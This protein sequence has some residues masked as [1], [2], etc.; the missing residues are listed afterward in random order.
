MITWKE[1]NFT[2]YCTSLMW[3]KTMVMTLTRSSFKFIYCC[4]VWFLVN[5]NKLLRTT[6]KNFAYHKCYTYHSLGTTFS[7]WRI[8]QIF[9]WHL[10]NFVFV[11]ILERTLVIATS[12][13]IGE[14]DHQFWAWLQKNWACVLSSQWIP[15]IFCVAFLDQGSPKGPHKPVHNSLR[16]RHL[17]YDCFGIC[18]ILPNQ[19]TF[20]KCIIFLLLTK[21][22]C[23]QMKCFSGP[24]LAYGP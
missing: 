2:H 1:W 18:Y 14:S 10:G 21:C 7:C 12:T 13:A 22:L 24:D 16:A 19:Q 4:F 5:L 23:G 11:E 9:I 3:I 17:I 20:H 15:D 8:G 6:W